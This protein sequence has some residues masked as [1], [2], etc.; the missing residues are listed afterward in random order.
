[1]NNKKRHLYTEKC[2]KRKNTIIT[3]SNIGNITQ[4]I[5]ILFQIINNNNYNNDYN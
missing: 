2:K 5:F 4:T 1:M 3:F